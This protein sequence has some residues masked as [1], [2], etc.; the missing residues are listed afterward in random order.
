MLR[1][2]WITVQPFSAGLAHYF[3][4]ALIWEK[5][6]SRMRDKKKPALTAS[7]YLKKPA[8]RGL[9]TRLQL[10]AFPLDFRRVRLETIRNGQYFS[11][12]RINLHCSHCVFH[13]QAKLPEAKKHTVRTPSELL[14]K[15]L[16]FDIVIFFMKLVTRKCESVAS[17]AVSCKTAASGHKGERPETQIEFEK[18]TKN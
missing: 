17:D 4:I 16:S 12:T 8:N 11:R 10:D 1:L 13:S 3:S 14:L 7:V 6:E 2:N 18:K 5:R 15:Q 9:F